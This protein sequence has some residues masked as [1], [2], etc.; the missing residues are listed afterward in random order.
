MHN[1]HVKHIIIIYT[2]RIREF[3]CC[4]SIPRNEPSK[5]A[6]NLVRIKRIIIFLNICTHKTLL[7]LIHQKLKIL[8]AISNFQK[9]INWH[10]KHIL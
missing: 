6:R 5:Q 10:N 9:I 2:C 4:A 8:N 1:G 7:Y 3:Q